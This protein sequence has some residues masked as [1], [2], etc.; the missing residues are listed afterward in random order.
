LKEAITE[1]ALDLEA[2]A[3]LATDSICKTFVVSVGKQA[4]YKPVIMRTY[5]TGT[6]SAFKARIWE[7]GRATSA[8]PTFF[9]PVLIEGCPL[10]G[11]FLIEDHP[12]YDG[13]IAG[14]WN[15]PTAQAIAEA[16]K[17]WPNRQIGCLL[18]I[19]TG[20]EKAIQLSHGSESSSESYDW[21]LGK[22]TRQVPFTLEVARYC[23][24]CLTSCEII[25]HNVCREYPD[26]IMDEENYFRF[27]APQGMSGIGLEEWEKIGDVID[28]TEMYMEQGAMER[29]KLKVA[30]LLLNP[31][32][33]G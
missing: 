14:R 10:F 30:K 32:S 1:S 26:H 3:P 21:L 4:A 11:L 12:Y 17:I 5:D 13:G 33:A 19:G 18:S 8:A 29:R 6:T 9:E 2:D 31:Q 15:N 25:H 23:I 16:Y 22:L 20:L 24:S 7:A 28:L 27:N